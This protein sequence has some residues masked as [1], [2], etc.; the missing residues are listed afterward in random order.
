[1]HSLSWSPSTF[2]ESIQN[3][4]RFFSFSDDWKESKRKKSGGGVGRRLE[5]RKICCQL[6]LIQRA[7]VGC[8]QLSFM[9]RKS[10][11]RNVINV[12]DGFFT[13]FFRMVA[14]SHTNIFNDNKKRINTI[15]NS[16]NVI[17]TYISNT[18]ACSVFRS[19][20]YPNM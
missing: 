8:D 19:K 17:K 14:F 1:M 7:N 15:R 20:S 9:Q 16:L 6:D 18:N 13:P 3:M 10:L 2:D 4:F 11:I 5:K 12:N